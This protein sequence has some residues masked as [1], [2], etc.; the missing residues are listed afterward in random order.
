MKNKR[1][2]TLIELLAVIIILGV[3]MLIAIPSVTRFINDSRKK[4]Y[5][6]TAQQYIKGAITMVNSGE[7]DIY[8]TSVTYYIP[9]S[10]I[11]VESGGKSPYGGEF[12]YAYIIVTYANDSYNFYWM[13]TDNQKIGIKTP[14]SSDRLETTSIETNVEK[15]DV[16]PTIGIDGRNTIVG[17]D[18]D[19]INKKE[20]RQSSIII[21]G[22]TGKE[23][24]TVE[25][26]EGKNK[27]TVVVGDIVRIG[28]EE[29]YVIKNSG[30]DLV[31]LAHY[32]LKVGSIYN[33]ST[34]I[35]DYNSDEEGYGIQSSETLGKNFKGIVAFSDTSYWKGK[36]GDNL[37]YPGIYC[38]VNITYTQ[39]TNCAYVFDE[40]SNL[41]NYVINYRNYL[42]NQGVIIKE[43][44]LLKVEEAYELGCEN[45]TSWGLNNCNNAPSFILETTFWL[46][47]AGAPEYPWLINSGPNQNFGYASPNG[48]W[49]GLRPVIV[50]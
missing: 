16:L 13:S 10:C 26:P 4:S 3:I 38:N 36:V 11:N 7:L 24:K 39:E 40:N 42:E 41:Y 31:L 27:K 8:D 9:S 28:T 32:N 25:Y 12:S 17:F 18:S 14:T 47:S 20:P 29:F 23:I 33:I 6:D 37:K 46:G 15:N 35:R 21:N 2:F 44:R 34:K 19:C 48:L 45:G 5:I 49:I 50:I 30:N 22:K 43:A 1:G